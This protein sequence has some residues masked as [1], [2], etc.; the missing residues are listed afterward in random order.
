MG[1]FF[2]V[3][4]IFGILVVHTWADW[5]KSGWIEFYH[6]WQMSVQVLAVAA[7]MQPK[8]KKYRP[9]LY[10]VIVRLCLYLLSLITGISTEAI[11]IV[12]FLYLAAL[13]ATVYLTV[14]QYRKRIIY[15]L[16]NI[17]PYLK[18]LWKQNY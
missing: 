9:I 10:Y 4:L 8:Y 12:R 18:K 5:S 15:H 3:W 17:I 7:V 1:E 11:P 13:A 14:Y 16:E 6:F 2:L